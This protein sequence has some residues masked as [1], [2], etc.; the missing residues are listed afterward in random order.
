MFQD[1][2]YDW[3]YTTEPQKHAPNKALGAGRSKWLQGK[4]LGGTSLLNYMLY[5]RGHP[6]DFDEWTSMGA[7]GWSYK[8][9]LPYFKKSERYHGKEDFDTAYHNDK[10]PLGVQQM[11]NDPTIEYRTI[12]ESALNEMG[13]E[14]GDCN[15]KEQNVRYWYQS[16]QDNGKRAD[17]YSAF[18]E[19]WVGNGLTVLTY[20]H[21]TKLI[22]DGGGKVMKGIKVERFGQ[23]LD[24]FARK[25]VIVS[26]GAIGS[27][28]LLMLSGIGPK[29]HLT[30]IGI[31]TIH[32]LPGVGANLQNHLFTPLE[33]LNTED[34]TKWLAA[35]LFLHCSQSHELL[36]I[37][38]WT[39]VRSLG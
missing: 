24:L 4:G 13:L 25:E 20:A 28:H 18:A 33:I 6:K 34:A 36:E 7:E 16:T 29:K 2:A 39:F 10:G 11:P 31:E 1:T 9:V 37:F 19:P 14:G 12:Y 30:D 3:Q 23:K 35:S 17:T 26:A 5:I 8:D 27:P 15:G 32:D 38:L 21:A 22:L